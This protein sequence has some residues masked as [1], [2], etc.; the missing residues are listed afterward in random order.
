MFPISQPN[1][2]LGTTMKK[3]TAILPTALFLF[4]AT[5]TFLESGVA[6]SAGPVIPFFFFETPGP[7]GPRYTGQTT[8]LSAS[9]SKEGVRYGKQNKHLTMQFKNANPG[10]ILRPE[11]P[12]QGKVNFQFGNDARKWQ[13]GQSMFAKLKYTELFDG[14]DLIYEGASNVLKSEYHIRAG[15]DY[16]GIEW[17]YADA[18]E[19]KLGSDGQLKIKAGGVWFEER[20][21]EAYEVD[22]DGRKITRKTIYELRGNGVVGFKVE[23]RNSQN[24]LVID[25]VLLF[26][27]YL[28]GRQADAVTAV[29][30]DSSNNIYV[31]GWTESKDFPISGGIHPTSAGGIDAFVMKFAG[32]GQQLLWATYFGGSGDDRATSIAVDVNGNVLV[33]GWTQSTNF[34]TSGGQTFGGVRDGFVVKLS[35]AGSSV[36]SFYLGGSG[37]DA[38]NAVAFDPG[39]SAYALGETTSTNFPVLAARQSTN[40]GGSDAFLTSYQS[41]GAMIYS[42]L[43]GGSGEDRGLA[44]SI[45]V[46]GFIYIAG[47]TNSVNFP[48]NNALQAV[49]KGGQSGFITKF[50][51]A[52]QS[53]VFSTYLGGS[54]GTALN[55]EQVTALALD[56]STNVFVAGVTS[57]FDFPVTSTVVQPAYGGGSQDGFFAKLNPTGTTLLYSSFFGGKGIDSVQAMALDTTGVM[58][59]TGSTT[60]RNLPVINALPGSSYKNGYDGF[61]ARVRSDATAFETLTYL[62]GTGADQVIGLA[63][64]RF[65]FAYLVGQTLSPDFPTKYPYSGSNAGTNGGFLLKLN[66]VPQAVSMSPS[67][68]SGLTG[69]FDFLFNDG[70]GVADFSVVQVIIN[71]TQSNTSAC[72]FY[73]QPVNGIVTILTDSGGNGASGTPGSTT[74]LQNSQCKIPLS[75]FSRTFAGNNLT[76]RV[77]L[78]FL[79]PFTGPKNVY[80]YTSDQSGGASPWQALGTF[81]PSSFVN[82]APVVSATPVIA[83]SGYTANFNVTVNDANGYAD[84]GQ[85]VMLINTSLNGNNACFMSID[86][87][88]RILYLAPDTTGDWAAIAFGTS[89]TGSNSTCQLLG[90][91]ISLTGAGNTLTLQM[92]LKFQTAQIGT[93]SIYV[94]AYDQARADSTWVQI[95]AWNLLAN[96]PPQILAMSPANGSGSSATFNFNFADGNGFADLAT[97]QVLINTN[98]DGNN[99]CYLLLDRPLQ[100]IWLSQTGGGFAG[101]PVGTGTLSNSKCTVNVA[102]AT[103]TGSGNNLTWSVPITFQP[104]FRGVKNFYLIT[105][106]LSLVSV[107]WVT[108]GSFNVQ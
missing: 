54:K 22:A 18:E 70:N 91:D 95:G 108:G 3:L 10:S 90:S 56:A 34:P 7:N 89:N 4:L 27:T 28:G 81:T 65:S 29:S 17:Q 49:L 40:A 37:S 57:S 85:I 107:G 83:G 99:A 39:G 96:Q 100:K 97:S 66:E 75:S 46:T 9:F 92:K 82:V 61:Y 80:G 53:I 68:G 69:T 86:V 98:N 42:T 30:T 73:Y 44:L 79:S 19:L 1:S 15:A 14:T 25:P 59:I 62:G 88:G 72:S 64:D 12:L 8:E 47:T 32:S 67:S 102:G 71:A 35:T 24:R 60:S 105:Q 103:V 38:V 55:P 106:D 48:L 94:L 87:P 78:E 58:H 93:K 2:C 36:Y 76:M 13:T 41:G 52:A 63:L 16:R 23:G 51:P 5:A 84:I 101:S 104:V 31:A 26:S 74:T 20:I 50:T 43:H 33:G 45:D 77:S 6:S 21:P 11:E